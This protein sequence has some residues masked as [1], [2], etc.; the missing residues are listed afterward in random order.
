L[1]IPLNSI[2][3]P[4][5]QGRRTEMNKKQLQRCFAKSR[6]LNRKKRDISLFI[7]MFIHPLINIPIT[8]GQR[9]GQCFLLSKVPISEWG[10]ILIRSEINNSGERIIRLFWSKRAGDYPYE[11]ER[12]KNLPLEVVES[13]WSALPEVLDKLVSICPPLN[14][15]FEFYSK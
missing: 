6:K 5:I 13:I 3:P 11:L 1:G 4:R 15:I 2:E 9:K 14:E 7:S 12:G 10:E 8:D